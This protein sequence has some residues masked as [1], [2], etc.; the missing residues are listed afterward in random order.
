MVMMRGIAHDRS[1][2]ARM[3]P[4]PSDAPAVAASAFS[5]AWPP[6]AVRPGPSCARNVDWMPD[7]QTRTPVGITRW[8]TVY[9][10]PRSTTHFDGDVA[11][12]LMAFCT[13]V[14]TAEAPPVVGPST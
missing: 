10:P 4:A 2:V 11:A 13:C 5:E 14:C 1:V 7:P 9:V 8:R 6:S 3:F 12:V